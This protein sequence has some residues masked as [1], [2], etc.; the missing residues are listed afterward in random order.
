MLTNGNGTKDRARNNSSSALLILDMISNFEF[1]DGDKLRENAL[2]VAENI[3]SLKAKAKEAGVPVIYVNDSFGVVT[4]DFNEFLAAIGGT[5]HGKEIVDTIAPDPN[6]HFI[7]K[8][9]RS[10]FYATPLGITLFDMNVS[11]VAIAGLTTDICVLFTAND[12]Y[13]RGF[14]IQIPSDCTAAVES[15]YHEEALSFIHRVTGAKV[16]PSSEISFN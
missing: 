8:P 1:E 4:D 15:N 6:D 10:G 13:M 16:A 3:A 2:P 11:N 12:A 7:L 5:K 14:N 9:Q